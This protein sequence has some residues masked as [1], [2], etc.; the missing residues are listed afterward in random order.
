MGR[1]STLRPRMQDAGSRKFAAPV[2]DEKQSGWGS[3][4]GGRPWRR[5]REAILVRDKYT[6]QSCGLVTSE[7]EVDHIINVARGG[8]DADANLQALCVPCHQRKTAAE[9]AQGGGW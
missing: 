7:L 3:G 1:L 5:K 4:R 6:C 2:V 9:A 8:S